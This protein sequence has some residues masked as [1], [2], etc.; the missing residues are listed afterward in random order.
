ME[1]STILSPNLKLGFIGAGNMAKAIVEG[2]IKAKLCRPSHI[3]I[4][5]PSADQ[6]K[7][8]QHLEIE[9][10]VES[11]EYVVKNSD[12]IIICVKPQVLETACKSFRAF[13][14][15]ERHL[16]ISIVAGVSLDKLSKYLL[17]E[18][19]EPSIGSSLR[20]AKCTMNLAAQLGLSASVFSQNG[21]LTN[22]DKEYVVDLLSSIGICAG[23]IKDSD[24]GASLALSGSSLAYMYVMVDAMAD[25]G[26]KMGL[27]RDM[28]LRMSIQTMKGASEILNN[29]LG[30]KHPAQLKDEVCSPGGTTIAGLHELE[31]NGFRNSI[32]CAIEAATNRAK[33]FEN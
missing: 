26:V 11:N 7:Y 29:E 31:R 1:N 24:M 6:N 27:K 17:G 25:A 15:L 19:Y 16:V 4:S 18:Y 21:N 14:E 28:A 33:Q 12:I 9:N 30:R 20:L 23:E 22:D 8:F 5:H 2:M 32:I 10:E 13:L 3:Y